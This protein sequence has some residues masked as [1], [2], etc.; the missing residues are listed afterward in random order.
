MD[1]AVMGRIGYDLFAEERGVALKDVS[2]FSRHLGG[3]S[4]NMAV[5]LARLGLEAAMIGCVGDDALGDFLIEYL[6]NEGVS[7]ARV[8]RLQGFQ[9]SLCLCETS[10]PDHFPQVFYRSQAADT[11]L[12]LQEDDLQ[13]ISQSRL[14]VTNGTSLCQSPSRES[15]LKAM[16]HAK[17]QGVTVAFDVD[18]REAS[19]ESE[20]DAALYCRLAL[21]FIDLLLANQGELELMGGSP[22]ER[23]IDSLLRSGPS[24]VVAKLDSEGTLAATRQATWFLP[25][26]EVPVVSTIGAGDGFGAGFLHGQVKGLS[27]PES[28]RHG[29]AAAALVVSRL[30]CADAMPR[31]GELHSLLEAH[32]EPRPRRVS[33]TAASKDVDSL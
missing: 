10:P 1:V 22:R 31:E 25:V 29:N 3:S 17:K 7:T 24:T 33:V 5:G 13:A 28:L 23:A 27:L 11:Q 26:F 8:R 12:R 4:A 32:P 14:F 18:Y 21:P 16:E 30:M 15:T 6:Q 20:Q 2:R 19:W 9:S